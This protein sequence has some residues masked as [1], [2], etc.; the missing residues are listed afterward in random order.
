MDGC[1]PPPGVACGAVVVGGSAGVSSAGR[2]QHAVSNRTLKDA[3]AFS[4]S[5]AEK[6]L[7]PPSGVAAGTA[8]DAAGGPRGLILEM[9]LLPPD[10]P[11][12]NCCLFLL[13]SF[14]D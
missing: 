13:F 5:S 7:V 14:C 4:K 10:L 8:D 6:P 2:R 3:R 11:Y 12:R 1:R 9:S